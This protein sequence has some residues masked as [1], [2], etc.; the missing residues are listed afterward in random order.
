MSAASIATASIA[1]VAARRNTQGLAH[2]PG[3]LPATPDEAYAIQADASQR[4]GDAVVGWKVGRIMGDLARQYGADR[5]IGPIF[6]STV[7]HCQAAAAARF[8]AIKGGAAALEAEVIA[9]LGQLVSPTRSDWAPEEVS[10]LLSGLHIGIEVAG[11]SVETIGQLG[12][13]ASI[14]V[15]GNNLGLIVGP[16]INNWQNV[17]IDGIGCTTTIDGVVIASAVAG[18]LPGG[19]LTA[20]A[21]ALNQAAKLGITLPAGTFI[22][23]GAITGVHAVTIGQ[24]CIADFGNH[25]TILC[26]VVDAGD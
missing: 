9:V 22:S 3:T 26:D 13:L 21:F 12:P 20:I 1:L 10:A 14:A 25:G 24:A 18:A 2:Y 23:T 7:T 17:D 15:F 5:F 4:F 11:C 19:P 8:P 6:A 16:A